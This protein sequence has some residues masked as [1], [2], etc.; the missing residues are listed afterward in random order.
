ME[1]RGEE[2]D[3]ICVAEGKM[4]VVWSGLGTEKKRASRKRGGEENEVRR[5]KLVP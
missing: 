4:C 2:R 5:I 1:K 3:V